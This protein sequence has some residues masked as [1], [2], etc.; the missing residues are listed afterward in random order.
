VEL[1]THSRCPQAAQETGK[2]GPSLGKACPRN[3][4]GPP[5]RASLALAVYP[6]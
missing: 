2:L 1:T 4:R 3:E 6:A 5:E